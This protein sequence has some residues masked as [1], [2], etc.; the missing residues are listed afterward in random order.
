MTE[1]LSRSWPLGV[2]QGY[3]AIKTIVV[4][5]WQTHSKEVIQCGQTGI[6]R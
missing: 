1:D 6:P 3:E 2:Q 4:H 5:G